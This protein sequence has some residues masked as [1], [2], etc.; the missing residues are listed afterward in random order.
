MEF[1]ISQVALNHGL[2]FLAVATGIVVIV[3]GGFIVKLLLDL[4]VLAKNVN[5]TSTILNE[6]LKPTLNELNK[7]ISSFNELVQNTGEGVDNVKLG[8]ENVLS[9]TKFF[10]QSLFG[11]ILK[12]F[13]TAYSLFCKKR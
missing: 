7:T 3:V 9:K 8:L 5:T 6:E 1:E 11:G 4:S 12:G 13:M 10:S 2:T